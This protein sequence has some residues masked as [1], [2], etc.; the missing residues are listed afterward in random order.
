MKKISF[1]LSAL[2]CSLLLSAQTIQKGPYTVY[3]LTDGVFH[4][5]DANSSNPAGAKI[6]ED[7]KMAGLNNCSE[8]Y[9]IVG[10][11][12][13]LLIDLSNAIKWDS[14]ATESL[15]SVVYERVG[16]KDFYITVTHKHGDHLGMLPAFVNDPKANFWVPKAEFSGMDIFPKERTNYFP[17]N[18]SLDLGGGFIINTMEVPGH[19]E[20]STLFFVRDKNI[21]FTGDAIGSGTGVWLFNY[22]SFITYSKA[23]DNL[24]KYIKDPANHINPDKLVIWGGHYW[25]HGKL[26][27]LTVQYVYDMQTLIGKIG[28]GTADT[29]AMTAFVAFLNTNFKYGTATISW[30]KEAAV[31]YAESLRSK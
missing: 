11:K 24:V 3:V 20:H 14:T 4:I 2:T 6:G 21:V 9:L 18:E 30:N 16:S 22:E 27:K 10:E 31:K 15:R 8:M 13:A 7:G 19:T 28:T 1:L 5:E 26:D 17:E 23:I 25:Q 12:K 29:E